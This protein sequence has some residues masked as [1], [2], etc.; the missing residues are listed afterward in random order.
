MQLKPNKPMKYWLTYIII[1]I[2]CIYT[3]VKSIS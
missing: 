2:R 1:G 3:A